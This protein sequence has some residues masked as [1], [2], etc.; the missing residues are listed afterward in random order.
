MRWGIKKG[1]KDWRRGPL[2]EDEVVSEEQKRKRR[3]NKSRK[4]WGE[5]AVVDWLSRPRKYSTGRRPR[6]REVFAAKR[7]RARFRMA[8]AKPGCVSAYGRHSRNPLRALRSLAC[9]VFSSIYLALSPNSF[10]Y[11]SPLSL[12]FIRPRLTRPFASGVPFSLDPRRNSCRDCYRYQRRCK[13]IQRPNMW[14]NDSK[15]LMNSDSFLFSIKIWILDGVIYREEQKFCNSTNRK[16]GLTV[17]LFFC[18]V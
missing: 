5:E 15:V 16:A 6:E 2:D 13:F 11:R 9:S 12:W 7:A 3:K 18:R 14:I 8:K 10:I 1:G 17:V 4:R